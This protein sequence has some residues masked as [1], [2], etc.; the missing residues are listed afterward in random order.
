MQNSWMIILHGIRIVKQAAL[1]G[2]NDGNLPSNTVKHL[3]SS[4]TWSI[5][6]IWGSVIKHF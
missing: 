5:N 2:V 4:E 1:F 3:L 6:A